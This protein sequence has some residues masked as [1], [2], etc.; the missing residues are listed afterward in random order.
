MGRKRK[1]SPEER[2]LWGRVAKTTQPY[3]PN[4]RNLA[5]EF[6]SAMRA[7]DEIPPPPAQAP[8]KPKPA[9]PPAPVDLGRLRLAGK[10]PRGPWSHT[11]VAASTHVPPDQP[12]RMDHKAHRNMTRG[13]IKPD[14]RIDL[15]GMTQSEAHPELIRFI[16]RA[17]DHGHRLVLVITGKGKQRED[18]DPIPQRMGVLRHQVPQWLRIAPLGPVVMQISQAHQRHGGEG[19]YYVYLR[20]LR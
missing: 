1:L 11:P 18:W 20:R 3:D 7:A 4:R 19:A 2:D 14:A 15:H 9:P 8:Q 12:L 10:P 17:Q 16:L 13:R 6:S 5:G